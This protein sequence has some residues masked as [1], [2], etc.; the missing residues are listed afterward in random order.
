M[1]TNPRFAAIARPGNAAVVFKLRIDM[2]DRGGTVEFL[3][4]YAT[5]EPARDL[6]LQMFMGEKFG[7]DSIWE[8]HL[9]SEMWFTDVELKAVL[10]RQTVSLGD[11][12]NFRVGSVLHLNTRTDSSVTVR[13]GDVDMFVGQLGRVGEKISV[14][15]DAIDFKTE[16][17]SLIHI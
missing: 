4:P 11:V 1:E 15:V 7:R 6:L 12:I 10:D 8:A 14:R 13:C 17:L 9:A 2:E 16:G 3:I 5:L